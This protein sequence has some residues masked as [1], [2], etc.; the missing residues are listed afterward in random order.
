[1]ARILYQWDF[2]P[3]KFK[4]VPPSSGSKADVA[5]TTFSSWA[6]LS[7]RICDLTTAGFAAEISDE[8]QKAAGAPKQPVPPEVVYQFVSQKITTVDVPID[9]SGYVKR[10]FDDILKSRYAT[11]LDKALF[12][13]LAL[14]Q[15]AHAWSLLYSRETP[16]ETELPRPSLLS[17]A[18]SSIL[19]GGRRLFL[20][21]DIGVAPFG[22]IPADLRGKKALVI[23]RSKENDDGL[24]E[25][26][27]ELPF[28]ATQRVSIDAAITA[29]GDLSA[30]VSYTMRGDNELLLR[31]AFH[32]SP[33]EKWNEVAQLLSLSD[34]FRG[35]VTSASATDPYSTGE[36]FSVQYEISQAKFVDWT[37][38]PVRIPAILPLVGL[39]EP[40]AGSGNT[41][42]ELGTPLDVHTSVTLRLP[43]GTTAEYPAGSSVER[44]YATFSS[45]YS[46]KGNVITASRQ[47]RFLLREVPRSRADDY[48]AFLHIVQG[49]QAQRFTLF[50]SDPAPTKPVAPAKP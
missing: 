12:L 22:M 46:G 20:A 43:P 34:G 4:D 42:I 15:D 21:A 31:V 30:K 41:P 36:P 18:L 27:R 38:K 33:R 29:T 11:S 35:K 28:A 47:I 25:I 24:V 44:D 5:L 39:P 19:R 37:K 7:A 10:S 16:L 17:G 3:Q 14:R 45:Q 13:S 49:D 40:P 48:N 2:E 6:Q 9:L 26:S 50:P 8:L 23:R 32:Q 1:S